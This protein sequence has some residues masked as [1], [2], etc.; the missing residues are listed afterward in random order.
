M[1]QGPSVSIAGQPATQPRG[2]TSSELSPPAPAR[3]VRPATSDKSYFFSAAPA[4]DPGSAPP[5]PTRPCPGC[6]TRR[7]AAPVL[8]GVAMHRQAQ[9]V[10]A[11]Q[12]LR[13]QPRLRR[14]FRQ[15]RDLHVA[16]PG[17][18]LG[19]GLQS[20]EIRAAGSSRSCSGTVSTMPWRNAPYDGRNTGRCVRPAWRWISGVCLCAGPDRRLERRLRR[21]RP[22]V[23]VHAGAAAARIARHRLHRQ[24]IVGRQQAGLDQRAQQGDGAGR[25]AAGI[26]HPRR[27]GDAFVC[28]ASF[29]ES[30]RPSPRW[31]DARNW[32]R[33]P[34]PWDCGWTPPPAAPARPAG[35]GWRYRRR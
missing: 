21:V 11:V 30:H 12:R 28:R 31:C 13:L 8:G 26:A 2:G 22:F 18:A 23:G 3:A 20:G 27:A 19:A 4:S 33:S 14:R 34:A 24:R 10:G 16:R 32:R 15:R 7:P 35:T 6:R 17:I 5:R 29:R 25:I 1:M 9:V